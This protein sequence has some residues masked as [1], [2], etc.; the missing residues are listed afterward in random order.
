M[1]NVIKIEGLSIFGTKLGSRRII[2]FLGLTGGKMSNSNS[3]NGIS[4]M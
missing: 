1:P 3:A 2:N 4:V